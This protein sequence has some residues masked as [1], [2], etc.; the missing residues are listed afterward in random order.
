MSVMG[1]LGDQLGHHADHVSFLEI[2]T[3]G[4]DESAVPVT[5][6]SVTV[7]CTKCGEVVAELFNTDLEAEIK[8]E[9]PLWLNNE[10]QFAR[11]LCELVAA[12]QPD[13]STWRDLEMSMDLTAVQLNSLFDRAHEVWEKSKRENCS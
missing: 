13:R 1:Y 8:A 11:L 4:L 6:L 3:Y 12:G 2:A 9:N 5:P 10:V 7:E